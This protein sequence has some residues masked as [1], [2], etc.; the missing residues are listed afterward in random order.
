MHKH[1]SL[2]SVD[3]GDVQKDDDHG[4]FLKPL[5]LISAGIAVLLLA[6]SLCTDCNEN[7]DDV[8]M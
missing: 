3:Q 1:R 5:L 4:I 6:G 8:S 2:L 7:K